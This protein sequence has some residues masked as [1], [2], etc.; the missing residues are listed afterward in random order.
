MLNCICWRENP[1]QSWWPTVFPGDGDLLGSRVNLR[2]AFLFVC[3]GIH[4]KS[5]PGR[6]PRS[7]RPHGFNM[8]P[9]D[10]DLALSESSTRPNPTGAEGSEPSQPQSNENDENN[11][12]RLL[13]PKSQDSRNTL[14][15]PFTCRC[16]QGCFDCLSLVWT[17]E[18]TDRL[19]AAISVHFCSFCVPS[20]SFRQTNPLIFHQHPV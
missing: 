20:D 5:F 14:P 7:I 17:Q 1:F 15:L 11:L 3:T 10:A 13:Y 12:L 19:L 8:V 6:T 2:R 16:S 18:G 9:S 4:L